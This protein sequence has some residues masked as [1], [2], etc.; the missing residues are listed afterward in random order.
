MIIHLQSVFTNLVFFN[1][2]IGLDKI[3]IQAEEKGIE[4]EFAAN[5]KI[6]VTNLIPTDCDDEQISL[7][8]ESKTFCEGGGDVKSVVILQSRTAAIVQF[9]K[10]EGTA[11]L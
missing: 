11:Y 2:S 3:K 10:P 7:F 8:F 1:S 6:L 5:D 9:E 4:V